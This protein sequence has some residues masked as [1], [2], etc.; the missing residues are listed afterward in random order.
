MIDNTSL[1]SNR[2]HVEYDKIEKIKFIV[3]HF[4]TRSKELYNQGRYIT[5]DEM[6]VAYYGHYSGFK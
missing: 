1:Q 3:E 2:S 6:M 5:V 4:V